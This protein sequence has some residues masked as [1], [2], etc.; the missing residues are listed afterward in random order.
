MGIVFS[1][2]FA[3]GIVLFTKVETEQHLTHILFG[4]LLGVSR[5][6]LVQTFYY[7]NNHFC[8]HDA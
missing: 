5:A 3:F 6:E 1:G 8:H 7:C 2:M 4:N